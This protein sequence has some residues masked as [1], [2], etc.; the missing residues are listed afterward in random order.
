VL[1]VACAPSISEMPAAG[2]ILSPR[3]RSTLTV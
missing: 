1:D 3:V 2:I